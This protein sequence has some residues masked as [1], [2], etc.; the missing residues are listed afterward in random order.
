MRLDCLYGRRISLVLA[1]AVT[2][3]L[4]L[5]SAIALA[6]D[7]YTTDTNATDDVTGET[8]APA[9]PTV[10]SETMTPACPTAASSTTMAVSGA[11]PTTAVAAASNISDQAWIYT[12]D[13][14]S[15]TP[16]QITGSIQLRATDVGAAATGTTTDLANVVSRFTYPAT[17]GSQYVVRFTCVA[18]PGTTAM[19]FGGV[20]VL[21]P[22]FGSTGVGWVDFPKT[23]AYV[24]VFGNASITKDGAAAADSVPAAAMVTQAVHD[25]TGQS[26]M[27][28]PD[29]TRREIHLIIPG[30][31]MPGGT[32]API[33]PEGRL[34]I[35]WPDAAVD[36]RNIGGSVT[37]TDLAP[38]PV[39]APTPV[40]PELGRGPMEGPLQGTI[41]ISLTNSG[42]RKTVGEAAAGL[43][44]VKVTNNSS[45][46]RGLIFS[47]IDICCS[48]Y[49]RFT[50]L[51]TPGQSQTFR[52]FFASGKVAI[53]D[54]LDARRA[55]RSFDAVIP[56]RFSSSIVFQ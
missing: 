8:T 5:F 40:P 54:F 56:G 19:N 25:P 24:S 3:I 51:L 44:D 48:P 10:T 29:P 31:M 11:G 23:L 16:Q 35:Y 43:W 32:A 6:Q 42:I 28:E 2:T 20:G 7:D 17:D 53:K 47:G 36:I 34:Y 14:R 15:S 1:L 22:V 46:C 30:T 4:C 49:N 55:G 45:R 12:S 52:F 38:P 9:C 39:A 41:N 18:P 26:L 13:F 50:R 21:R 27:T 33:C 37:L